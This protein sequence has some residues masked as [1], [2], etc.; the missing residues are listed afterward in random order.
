L[1][2]ITDWSILDKLDE[3]GILK[4]DIQS[5][6]GELLRTGAVPSRST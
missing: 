2:W 3:V 6:I 4:L 1:F 5:E